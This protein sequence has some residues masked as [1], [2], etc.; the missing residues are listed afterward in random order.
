[1]GTI[2][3][4]HFIILLVFGCDIPIFVIKLY[5]GRDSRTSLKLVTQHGFRVLK[6]YIGTKVALW[7]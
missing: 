1:M 7:V 3:E 4:Y 6:S 2:P 5:Y